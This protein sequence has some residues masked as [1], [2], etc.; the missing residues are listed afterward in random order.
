MKAPTISPIAFLLARCPR[1]RTGGIFGRFF[2][3][4]ERCPKCGLPFDS[5]R[6]YASAA[7]AISF[8]L[9][10]PIIFGLMI[11]LALFVVPDWPLELA[12]LP[13]ILLFA[14]FVPAVLLYSRVMLI[15][16]DSRWYPKP[17]SAQ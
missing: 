3:P 2:A 8:F 17:G 14:I 11:G 16:L 1:C 9:G 6:G 12:V 15:Y 13:A 7:W 4:N 10:F 5:E